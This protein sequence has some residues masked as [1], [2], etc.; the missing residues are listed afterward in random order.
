MHFFE[1]RNCEV[2]CVVFQKNDDCISVGR[3]E[4]QSLVKILEYNFVDIWAT[5]LMR[6]GNMFGSQCR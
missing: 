1:Y 2:I 5:D 4:V 6:G 3:Y